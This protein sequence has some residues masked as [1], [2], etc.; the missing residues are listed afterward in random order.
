[1]IKRGSY[2]G[3]GTML[4]LFGVS[5]G[6][7]KAACGK[8]CY[9]AV[10]KQAKQRSAPVQ[11]G[12]KRVLWHSDGPSDDVSSLSVLIDWITSG[13]NY[14]RYRGGDGQMGETKTGLVSQ[15]L[16]LIFVIGIKTVRTAKDVIAKISS[17][18]TFRTAVDWLAATDQGV[19]DESSLCANILQRCPEY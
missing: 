4:S 12:K 1:M 15:I 9:N 5:D 14:D 6:F 18:E 19:E 17:L 13:D 10:V 7:N 3:P 11:T 16:R 2:N 8:R